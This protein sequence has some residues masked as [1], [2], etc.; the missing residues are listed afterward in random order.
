MQTLDVWLTKYSPDQ[1]RA[2]AG[3]REGG[4][5]TAWTERWNAVGGPKERMGDWLKRDIPIAVLGGM[6]AETLLPVWGP[7][8]VI[9]WVALGEVLNGIVESQK[10]RDVG[11]AARLLKG[12]V[13]RLIK[14]RMGEMRVLQTR[15]NMVGMQSRVNRLNKAEDSILAML[16]ALYEALDKYVAKY[17]PDQLRAPKGSPEGG[18]WVRQ[19]PSH[20]AYT[21]PSKAV[22]ERLQ[23]GDFLFW[24]GS[25][26]AVLDQIMKEGITVDP[27][28]RNYDG[29]FYAG[30]RG[31]GIFVTDS[32]NDA[33]YWATYAKEK[34]A[35]RGKKGTPLIL[36]VEVP[37]RVGYE[38]DVDA[39][40]GHYVIPQ[41]IKPEWIKHAYTVAG[42][43]LKVD[44][45]VRK[46][47]K[48]YLVI[49][50]D[51]QIGKVWDESKHPRVPSGSSEGGQFTEGDL[52]P[53][54][55]Q[56]KKPP[57]A[58]PR[59]PSLPE[60]LPKDLPEPENIPIK[61]RGTTLARGKNTKG[62]SVALVKVRE[63]K[64]VFEDP[65]N[66]KRAT[67]QRDVENYQVLIKTGNYDRFVP[68]GIRYEWKLAVKS[69]DWS[70]AVSSFNRRLGTKGKL[71]DARPEL[72]QHFTKYS[73]DQ[74]RWPKGTH[75]GGQWRDENISAAQARFY[76]LKKRWAE[77]NNEL[78]AYMDR[79]PEDPE[80]VKRMDELREI[81]KEMNEL[82]A[83]PGGVEGIGFPGGAY[84][85]AIVGGGPGGLSASIMGETEGLDVLLIEADTVTGGQYRFSSRLENY[86]GFPIGVTGEELAERMFDQSERVGTEFML[87]TQV[88]SLGYDPATGLKSLTLANGTVITARNVVLAGGTEFNKLN[89]P[90][91]DSSSV[92]YGD[93][94][95]IGALAAGSSAVIIGGSN[96]A[97]Q[98][99]LGV[100]GSAN[101]VYVLSRSPITKSMSDYQVSA[102][103]NNPKVTVIENDTISSYK[104]GVVSTNGG[105]RLPAATVGIFAGSHPSTSWLPTSIA[106]DN[107]RVKVN[108][109]LE[110]SIPGVYAVGDIRAG[111]IGR[112]G[113]AVGDGQMAIKNIYTDLAAQRAAAKRAGMSVSELNALVDELF[114]LDRAHPLL[115]QTVDVDPLFKYDPDQPRAPKGSHEGGQWVSSLSGSALIG[116]N[117]SD[118]E[119]R[120]LLTKANATNREHGYIRETDGR[121][122]KYQAGGKDYINFP[123]SYGE[124]FEDPERSVELWHNH[125]VKYERSYN[126]PPSANDIYMASLPGIRRVYS[127]GRDGVAH[128]VER[129]PNF[130]TTFMLGFSIN[131]IMEKEARGVIGVEVKNTTI[132]KRLTERGLIKTGTV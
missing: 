44:E 51:N 82:E 61:V 122:I 16:K 88:V 38:I 107:G 1:P 99:A 83:D 104:N 91:S 114:D 77:V 127:V 57:V 71:M 116:S 37:K 59:D 97:A 17:S 70:E 115:G 6:A 126:N 4:R 123:D 21:H 13:V 89:F 67:G 55:P 128:W 23:N 24:H 102:I 100:A 33:L 112:V 53:W 121:I 119:M 20:D 131:R 92:I 94:R 10:A 47:R 69:T 19:A 65:D 27:G 30:Y 42:S 63:K 18:R 26:T 15:V 78:L 74:P 105:K 118:E 93:L 54:R 81:V 34:M 117:L 50:V 120:K 22:P 5:W 87:G 108:G 129:G 125:P 90:G 79:D 76:E 130:T 8:G 98:A 39:G 14:H 68:G 96:G 56:E 58:E 106:K 40:P 113:T 9:A 31:E 25:S 84:D 28:R 49:V 35:A 109:N 95:A 66:P 132:I 111:S 103:R 124:I 86:P 7:L 2:P 46:G 52:P 43:G 62:Q 80:I 29:I 110:T 85:V 11:E 36:E 48:L 12:K 73:P 101:H 3:T 41:K 72:R 60:R 75:E 45:L 32:F 64:W